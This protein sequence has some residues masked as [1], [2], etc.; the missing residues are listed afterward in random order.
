MEERIGALLIIIAGGAATAALLALMVILLPNLS[1][2]TS[3]TMET[4]PGRSLV[5]GAINFIFFFAVAFVLSQIGNGIGGFFGGL[6]SLVSLI[7]SIVLLLLLSIGL[8]GLVRL[9]SERTND[10]KPVSM[11]RLFRAAVLLVGASLAPLA[12]WFV[13]APLALFTG[14]GAT[15]IALVQWLGGR[16]SSRSSN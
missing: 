7:I 4:M 3:R 5:L 9:I 10:S 14:L 2:R 6:F 8:G 15:I 13:L 11:G 1:S 16:F 12:G